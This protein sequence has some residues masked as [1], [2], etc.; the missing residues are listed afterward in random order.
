MADDN[1]GDIGGDGS[2][3]WEIRSGDEIQSSDATPEPAASKFRIRRKNGS[4]GTR[5]VGLDN[6]IGREFVLSL[7][8]PTGV[9]AEEFIKTFKA[10]RGRVRITMPI[11]KGVAKQIK[12]RWGKDPGDV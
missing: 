11:E 12:I 7:R 3:R 5:C 8:P 1:G 4:N 9:S 2:V 10:K 6:K